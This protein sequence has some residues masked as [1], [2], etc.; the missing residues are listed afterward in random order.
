MTRPKPHHAENKRLIQTALG[1]LAAF[2]GR[3]T[4][5]RQ[6]A[7]A[8]AKPRRAPNR[9]RTEADEPLEHD[10]QKALCQW[11]F[12][13]S[14]TLGLDYRLLVATPNAM[15]MFRFAANPNALLQYLRSEGFRDG[16]LDLTLYVARGEY[17]GLIIEMK[18]R[19][20]GSVKPEQ[21]AMIEILIPQGYKAGVCRGSEEAIAVI[22]DYLGG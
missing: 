19:T 20:K 16:M 17:H 7:I 11:W 6:L 5:E 21:H 3:P 9:A 18:R 1:N 10:E 14:K 12:K 2:S 22:K 4:P 13:Y 8:T 15:A